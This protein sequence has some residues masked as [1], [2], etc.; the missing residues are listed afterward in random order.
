MRI[1]NSNTNRYMTLKPKNWFYKVF[2]K[3]TFFDIPKIKAVAQVN[4]KLGYFEGSIEVYNKLYLTGVA[5]IKKPL[6]WEVREDEA[7]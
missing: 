3:V 5:F 1:V 2:N 7:F 4:C 6:G